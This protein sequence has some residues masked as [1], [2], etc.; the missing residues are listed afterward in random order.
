MA[1]TIDQKV[2]LLLKYIATDNIHEKADLQAKAVK[3]L[4]GG[5]SVSGKPTDV[6]DIIADVLKDFGISSN[7]TGHRYLRRAIELGI[8]DPSYVKYGNV[9]TKLYPTL[10]KEY[11]LHWVAVERTIRHAINS[12]FRR[13]DIDTIT[14]MV[15]WTVNPDKGTPTN[16]EFL[17]ACVAETK[18]RMKELGIDK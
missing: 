13:G 5:R 11:G 18:R 15:G 4:K 9:T 2:D 14:K 10:A 17:C 1:Y 7:Y 6:E 16:S 8:R 12:G 3:M